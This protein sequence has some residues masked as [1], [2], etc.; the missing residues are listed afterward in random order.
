MSRFQKR[1]TG[2]R[3]N[4]GVKMR[5]KFFCVALFLICSLPVLVHA[6]F[7]F[8]TNSD[9]SL[10]IYQ[11]TG[12]GGDV[13]IPDTTNDVPVTSISSDAFYQDY[14]LT[15]VII[16]TNVTTIGANAIFQCPALVSVT[17]PASVTNIGSGP[18][19]DCLSLSTISLSTSNRYFFS[20]NQILFNKTQTSLIEFPG[21]VGGGYTNAA[22][23]TNIGQAFI[24]N[25]LTNISANSANLYFYSTNGVLFT[26]NQKILVEYPGGAS[27]SYA[28]PVIVTN[29]ESA[30]FE[31]S[32]GVTSVSIG[33]NVAGIG[34]Y[35]FYDCSALT[36]ISVN[37]TN[38]YFS[39]TNGVLFDKKQ[40]QLIQYPSGL[41]GSYSV[42]GTV[43]NLE[44]GAFGDAFGLT[45]VVIPDSVTSIG[46]EA[47][48]SC[49]NLANVS[50]G[51]NVVNIG[52][53]AFYYC[54]SLSEITIPYSVTNIAPLAFYYCPSLTSVTFGAGLKTIG[55]EAFA[56]CEYLTNAC[57]AGDEPVDG[58]SIFYYDYSLPTILYISGT[59]GWGAT[60]DGIA[61]AP[62]AECGNGAP[63]LTVIRSGTNVLL[64]WSSDYTGFTLQSTTN[65]TTAGI[66]NNVS[67][68]PAIINGLNTVT[69]SISGKQNFYRL[70]SP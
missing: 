16:G 14:T 7:T 10:N 6:Q 1:I 27:G 2:S 67:P 46:V 55:Q 65:L 23:I 56:G 39:A 17:I 9:H 63:I 5:T 59:T 13:I 64:T 51:N 25:S 8:T 40:T 68:A 69:N 47:F 22:A 50:L 41:A 32:A 60:Y 4:L 49:E 34:N 53:E 15:S 29:I 48:Y 28:V 35:A 20:T 12:P 19:I 42:P 18:F 31:Y 58:G 62:C 11:Y 43:T 30:A 37:S 3:L 21:G 33:T 66:W 45:S 44:N 54:T 38:Q 26:K 24:G 52:E 61:T 57:F 70:M 36:A